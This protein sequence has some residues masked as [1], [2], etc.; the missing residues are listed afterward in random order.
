[1]RAVVVHGAGDLRVDDVPAPVAGPGEVVL[2]LEWGGICGS[3]ISY[4]RHGSSGTSVI[5]EP[6]VLGH[7]VAG[8]V[9]S[10]GPGVTGV[11]V[12]TPVTVHPAVFG[13]PVEGFE[14]SRQLRPGGSYLAQHVGPASAFELIEFFTGPQPEARGE[15][16]GFLQGFID[17]GLRPHLELSETTQHFVAGFLGALRVAVRAQTAGRLGQHREQGG[18]GVAQL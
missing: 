3:D 4:W 9:R 6:L 14:A 17:G 1:M 16:Q 13:P 12:G 7:E 2:D 18:F 10:L 11:E 8:R 5:R 15:Q